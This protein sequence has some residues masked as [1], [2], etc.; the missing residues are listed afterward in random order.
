MILE[1]WR[2]IEPSWQEPCYI[3]STAVLSGDVQM[4]K[5]CNIWHHVV[6]RGDSGSNIRLGDYVNVQEC[7]VLHLSEDHPCHIGNYVTIGHNAII[8]GC[9]IEDNCLIGM[10]AII[11]NGAVIGKGSTV[12]AGALVTQN[13]IIPPNSLVVGFPAQVI[14]T[15]DAESEASTIRHAA[16]YWQ[17]ALE[18]MPEAEKTEA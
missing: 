6:M 11:M 14:R 3:A 13:M 8:H 5:K 18:F 16:G 7:S 12:G 4:G 17:H 1:K 10:G 2:G 15:L 9:T